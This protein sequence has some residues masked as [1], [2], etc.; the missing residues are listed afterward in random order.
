[1]MNREQI[2]YHSKR[3]MTELDMSL[4]AGSLLASRAH[5]KLSALH[6]E[7]LRALGGAGPEISMPIARPA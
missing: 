3:A 7:R 4:R 6:L 2:D 5:A 1:M